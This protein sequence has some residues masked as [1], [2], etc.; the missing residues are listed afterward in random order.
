MSSTPSQPPGHG[1]ELRGARRVPAGSA[2]TPGRFGR[3]FPH[4]PELVHFNPPPE[5]LGALGGPMDAGPATGDDNPRIRA[6]YTFLGQFIDHDLTLDVTSG[7][8]ARNDPDAIVNFRTPAFELDSLYGLGPAAQP[9]LYDDRDGPAG[10]AGFRFLLSDDAGDLPRNSR[11]RALV[12]DP[13]NDENIIVSQLHLLF[14]KFHNAVYDNHTDPAAPP[15]VRFENAQRLVRWHYQWIVAREFLPRIIGA[16]L[17]DD[18]FRNPRPVFSGRPFMPLEFSAA[19]YRFGHS[20]VRGGYRVNPD[21]AAPLFPPANPDPAARDLRGFRPVPPELRVDWKFFFGAGPE[22]Q[23]GKLVDTKLATPLLRL[24]DGVVPPGTPD[25]LRSLAVRNLRRGIAFGLPSG[26][27]V[28]AALAV[29]RP[30]DETEIWAG[31]PDAPPKGGPAPLW[32]YILKEAEIRAQ[33]KRLAGAGAEIV[34]RVFQALLAADDQ[35]WIVQSPGWT[36]TLPSKTPGT[37]AMTDL[38]AV[39]L[40]VDLPPEDLAALPDAP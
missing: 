6:G 2:A 13:R 25:P 19:A 15:A 32:Y 28:A 7:I 12:G 38:V 27:D 26:Q 40:G 14:L 16:A 18:V 4:L 9:Y 23:A 31:V 10:G 11:G 34:G 39:A 29:P 17:A 20:Q 30:L 33:G 24:P 5:R 3:L 36:P 22:A 35:S 37:F 1:V 21:A 8:E